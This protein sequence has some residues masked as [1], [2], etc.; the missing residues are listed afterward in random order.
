MYTPPGKSIFLRVGY[1][2]LRNRYRPFHYIG[3]KNAV[4]RINRDGYIETSQNFL[5]TLEKYILG[6]IVII[7]R[8]NTTN[9]NLFPLVI[10]PC[11]SSLRI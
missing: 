8:K 2:I 3:K 4:R 11:Y 9:S 7:R 5:M 1:V 6:S 10:P